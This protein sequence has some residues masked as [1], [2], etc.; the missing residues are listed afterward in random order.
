MPRNSN[1]VITH[2]GKAHFDDLFSVC[3]VIYKCSTEETLSKIKEVHRRNPTQTEMKDPNVWKL[4]IGGKFNPDLKQFDHH[5]EYSNSTSLTETQ[6]ELLNNCTFSLLLKEWGDWD[7]AVNIFSWLSTA[8]K[9]D[10]Q[11]PK[12]VVD[13]LDISFNVLSKLGSF[14]ESKILKLFQQCEVIYASDPFFS[15]LRY[16]GK[17]FF[18]Q[19]FTYYE[20]SGRIEEKLEF[21]TIKG[22]PS[23]KYLEDEQSL[24][25]LKKILSQ[26]KEKRWG[27][28][29]IVIYPNNRPPGSIAVMRYDDDERVDFTRIKD[30]DH[31]IFAHANGFFAVLDEQTS[32]KQLSLYIQDAI[33]E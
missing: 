21:L 11:G 31:V 22:V 13:D 27:E 5:L 2:P 9:M 10:A 14:I 32:E 29:G 23:I 25:T 6:H 15:L 28:G 19:L 1:I 33:V 8:M 4:D 26:I 7:R 30:Y 20:L 3:L 12:K 24:G 18:K 17:Q 16:F